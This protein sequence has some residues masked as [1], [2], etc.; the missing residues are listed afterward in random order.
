MSEALAKLESKIKQ[1]LDSMESLQAENRSFRALA[2]E[3]NG[4][5]SRQQVAERIESLRRE[6]EK[7][8]KKMSRL[9]QGISRVLDELDKLES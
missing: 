6:K 4:K 2:G 1:L 5:L 3:N 9:Q 7:L 8:E